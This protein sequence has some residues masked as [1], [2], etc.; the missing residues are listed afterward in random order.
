MMIQ[1]PQT[2]TWINQL[3]PWLSCAYSDPVGNLSRFLIND[4]LRGP[5]GSLDDLRRLQDKMTTKGR[6]MVATIT[7]VSIRECVM[8]V[9]QY[10]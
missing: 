6:H 9:V 1:V 2:P 10:Q 5:A 4:N 7:G 3:C 8:G